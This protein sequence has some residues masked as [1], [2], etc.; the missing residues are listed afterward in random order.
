[1]TVLMSSSDVSL[2]LRNSVLLYD[3]DLVYVASISET[4]RIRI[5][6]PLSGKMKDITVE[7]EK[8][9]IKAFHLGYFNYHDTANYC[10]RIPARQ[11]RRGM[12]TSN[13]ETR[14][15]ISFNNETLACMA[16]AWKGIFPT[17]EEAIRLI[18]LKQ[19]KGVAVSRNTALFKEGH[20]V[21]LMYMRTTVGKVEDREIVFEEGYEEISDSIL[22]G[23]GR[24]AYSW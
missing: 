6:F 16:I 2:R 9:D 1:M 18:L 15:G 7:D 19:R 17:L 20:V 23:V 12:C 11:V 8:L 14:F 4:G 22:K 24:N 5:V 21:S 3:G 10:S 13:I